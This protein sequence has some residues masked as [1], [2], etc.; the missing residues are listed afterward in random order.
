MHHHLCS[1]LMVLSICFAAALTPALFAEKQS[2][3]PAGPPKNFNVPTVTRIALP[4]GLQVRLVPYGSVPK[5]TV[6]LVTQTGNADESENETWL[7]DITSEM[8]QQGT[9]SQS[10]EDVAR[11]FAEMGGQLNVNSGVNQIRLSTDV[12]SES[13]PRAVALLGDVVRHPRFSESEVER[14]KGNFVRNLAIARSQQQT[15]A[16]ERFWSVLY[17]SH[18]YGRVYPT[19]TTLKGFTLDQ[20][21]SFY[22]RNF[23][24]ARSAIYVAGK[25]DPAAM[26]MAIRK[27]LADWKRGIPASQIKVTPASGRKVYLIDKPKAVQ[28]TVIIGLPSIEPS[29]PDYIPL[30][31]TDSLL[32]GS[33]ASRITSN[34]R[35]QKGYTYS[36][37]SQFNTR[38]G[39]GT[40]FE[41][42]DVTSNVT[43]P[44]IKEIFGE[45]DRLRAE[46]PAQEELRGIQNNLAGIFVLRNSSR[47]GIVNQL[48]FLDLY[49]L[50]EDFLRNYVQRVYALK[51][52]DVQR[53]AKQYLDPA[54]MAIVVVG[55]KTVIAEQVTPFGEVIQ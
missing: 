43:G 23:G 11:Q 22:E 34:I 31:V 25:F 44:S 9:V 38:L 32:G 3:P 54:K 37:T 45:I 47:G 35:E 52:A 2:P 4:N 17:P 28:S 21:K 41:V 33:F 13:G 39:A 27:S 55:D 51:P 15:L 12:F 49:G 8:L 36:P 30:V 48:A 6:A 14:V 24:A 7:A 5:V 10:A 18:A 16:T 53:I 1:R 46:A 19:E 50:S 40:W 29:S 20:M 42:A 26:E